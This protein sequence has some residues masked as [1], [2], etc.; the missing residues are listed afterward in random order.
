MTDYMKMFK[1]R[2][3]RYGLTKI[4]GINPAMFFVRPRVRMTVDGT[5]AIYVCEGV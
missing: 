1:D 2:N 5:P 3:P 4:Y